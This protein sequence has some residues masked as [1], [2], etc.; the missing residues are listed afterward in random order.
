[1]TTL[2]ILK[3]E[4]DDLVAELI[5]TL[6]GRDGAMVVNLYEDEI[7]DSQVDWDRLAADI[8]KADRVISWW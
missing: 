6:S 7:W 3:T 2:H 5:D 1:M 8:F 4:P